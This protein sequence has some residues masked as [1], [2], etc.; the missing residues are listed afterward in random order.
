[1][2]APA[3]CVISIS[4]LSACVSTPPPMMWMRVDGQQ[5]KGNPALEQEF[6]IARTACLGDSQ[7]ANMSG[8]TLGGDY[9]AAFARGQ[10]ASDVFKGCMAEK[11][12]LMVPASEV[13]ERAAAAR[14]IAAEKKG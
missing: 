12:Y 6:E 1:M 3:F 13:Q 9:S 14:A 8:V 7:K 11:G 10:A 2:K 5:G 4:V